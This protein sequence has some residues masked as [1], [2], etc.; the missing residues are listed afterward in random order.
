M[1]TSRTQTPPAG[2]PSWGLNPPSRAWAHPVPESPTEVFSHPKT[3]SFWLPY[4]K[5]RSYGDVCLNN[6]HTQ[7][8][9][10]FLDMCLGFDPHLGTLHAECG[11][12]LEEIL[13]IIVPHGWF[14][15]VSPG[16]KYVTLGGAIAN[17]IH[18]KNHGHRGC[19]GNH[20]LHLQILRSNGEMIECSPESRP[21][22]FHASVGGLGLTG[23][24]WSATL[25]L[26]PISTPM[27]TAQHIA[28]ESLEEF[29]ELNRQYESPKEY[30]VAWID[31]LNPQG[32]GIYICGDHTVSAHPQLPRSYGRNS[33]GL[34]IPL[35]APNWLLNPLSV[36]LFNQ[37]YY[38]LQKQ[39]S[40]PFETSFDAFFYP[41]DGLKNWNRL[42]GKR[43]FYQYQ[44]V[45][46]GLNQATEKGL[47]KILKTI[48]RSRQ[49]SFL[50]VLKTFGKI[51]PVGKLSFPT[52]GVTLA[53]DFPNNGEKT[54][55][56]LHQL[57]QHVEEYGGRLYPAKD[58][59]MSARAFQKQ[60]P[61]W[62][63]IESLRDPLISSSFWRRVTS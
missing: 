49:G 46:P 52:E 38:H 10:A 57:D 30:S 26:L 37:S 28:F 29:F 15:P 60:Y 45:L 11:I 16:T 22:W 7:A 8:P 35:N 44:C 31:T 47:S 18:G 1:I 2:L 6:G 51:A 63:E 61:A 58:A 13:K 12:T 42:Y 33:S 5:G 53:L 54:E 55:S 32:R 4:G 24:L 25:Q 50:A 41:L 36:K 21:E 59:H 48:A 34:S 19:I 56:L 40:Q 27:I 62:K 20:L 23:L 14:L 9:T 43:G 17:D 3:S 39:K